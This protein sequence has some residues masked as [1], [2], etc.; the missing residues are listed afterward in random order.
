M[1]AQVARELNNTIPVELIDRLSNAVQA[2]IARR[3]LNEKKGRAAANVMNV[4]SAP[5]Q[6]LFRSRRAPTA[7][8]LAG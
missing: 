4:N 3:K 7:R 1:S 2:E 6:A 8:P 5:A